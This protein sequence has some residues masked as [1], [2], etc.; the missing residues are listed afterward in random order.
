MSHDVVYDIGIDICFL[1]TFCPC[2]MLSKNHFITS[3]G[4]KIIQLNIF[5]NPHPNIIIR[6]FD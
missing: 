5:L 6:F 4:Q 3:F 2:I 1:Y